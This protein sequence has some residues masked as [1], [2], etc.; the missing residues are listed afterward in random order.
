MR[1]KLTVAVFIVMLA[2]AGGC[3]KGKSDPVSAEPHT[4]KPGTKWTGEA[5]F[6]ERCRDCHRVHDKGG[7]VGPDLSS[8][9]ST[10]SRDFLERVVKDPSKAYPG[11][12]MPPYDSLP[13]DQL[14]LL[15][16]YLEALK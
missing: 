16:D 15:A 10:R 1:D 2:L 12:V 6:I 7:V 8:V 9:G 14:K 5:I 13:A 3:S 11:T 4:L